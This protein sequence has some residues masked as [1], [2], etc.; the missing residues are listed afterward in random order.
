MNRLLFIPLA[1]LLAGTAQAAGDAAAGQAKA[2]I[3][4]ACHGI[5]GN[6]AVPQW[7]KLAGQHADYIAAQTRMVR[8]GQRQVVE[9]T[10]IVMGLSDQDIDDI[11][12]YYAGQALQPGVA[13]ESLVQTGER[14]YRAGNA[15][16]GVPA[17]TACHGPTGQGNPAASYPAV[18]GQHATYMQ[19]RLEKYR[20]GQV[21]GDKDP[22]SPQMVNVAKN[23]TD[24]EIQAV[25]SYMQ[26]LHRIQD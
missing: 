5:D 9:M 10:G 25:S 19:S 18:G 21:N 16:S 13:D 24:E 17:C 26:G 1:M 11:A 14:I 6:S 15:K 12:A 8:D 7:P 2:A 20:N 22:Y 3:C 4:A 23:L